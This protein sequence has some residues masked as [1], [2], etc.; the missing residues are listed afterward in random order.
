MGVPLLPAL[1]EEIY[2]VPDGMRSLEQSRRRTHEDMAGATVPDLR[3][4]RGRLT[5]RLLLEPDP[6]K[7][8]PWFEER[9][10][11][12]DDLLGRREAHARR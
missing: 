2:A 3:R 6:T 7:T 12:I 9:L 8:D 5:L 4:E 10:L 11:A 1:L